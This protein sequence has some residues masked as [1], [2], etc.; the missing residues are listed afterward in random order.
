MS[1]VHSKSLV[2]GLEE[3]NDT[4]DVIHGTGIPN[5]EEMEDTDNDD[6]HKVESD[7]VF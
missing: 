3:E 5:G 4:G 1:M 6:D 7:D 2:E